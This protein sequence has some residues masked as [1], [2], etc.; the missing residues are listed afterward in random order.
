[1][2]FPYCSP[3]VIICY[4]PPPLEMGVYHILTST[5]CI[6]AKF[7][8]Y[9]DYIKR[10]LPTTLYAIC[11]TLILDRCHFVGSHMKIIMYFCK[12]NVFLLNKYKQILFNKKRFFF[13]K[14]LIFI[15]S[16][17]FIA[18][19]GISFTRIKLIIK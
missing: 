16:N 14:V 13:T 10:R 3:Y 8:A 1:M 4:L 9:C 6:L 2:F 15:Y 5:H 17:Y 11:I 12:K 19:F 7:A 18:Q